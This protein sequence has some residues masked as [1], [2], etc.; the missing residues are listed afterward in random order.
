MLS[1]ICSPSE[2]KI[3]QM[4]WARLIPGEMA[5]VRTGVKKPPASVR[6]LAVRHKFAPGIEK[7][8]DSVLHYLVPAPLQSRGGLQWLR[9]LAADYT[10]ITLNW[11]VIG[12]VLVTWHIAFPDT[13]LFEDDAGRPGAFLGIGLL[14]AALITLMGYTEGIYVRG[15]EASAEAR[16]VGKSVLWATA[17][18][19]LAYG[20]QRASWSVSV[21]FWGAGVLDFCA[22]WGWRRW[23]TDRLGR[24]DIRRALIVGAG[25]VGRRIA[26]HIQQHPG[27]GRTVCGFLDDRRAGGNGVVGR[28]G[29]LAWAA[30]KQ[31]ADE[32]ILAAPHDPEI[33]RWVLS[34]A[35]RLRLDVE[36]VPDLYSCEPVEGDLESVGGLPAICLHAE[37]L[38]A[39]GLA[40]KRLAD[41]L[42]ATVSLTILSPLLAVIAILIKLDSQGPALYCAPRAGRKGQLFSCYKFRTMVTNANELKDRLRDSNE[43]SGPFFKMADDPRITRVGRYLRRYSLDELPQ[44]WNVLRGEMSLVGLRPHPL[45]DV[46]GYE[47][48]DLARLDVTPGMTGLW[49]I[50]A[51][52][53]PSFERGVEL[54]REYI[55]TWSLGSDLRILLRTIGVVVGGGG[56]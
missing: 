51:R 9:S 20:L 5:S 23:S 3:R 2:R 1:V 44:L 7:R 48:E 50:T 26:A 19:C 31:F 49:Q 27:N 10:L 14:H 21:L 30:R 28:V 34:E 24:R 8:R 15:H 17:V 13:W 55:R 12:A 25:K 45:D 16:I 36:I 29:D 22:L 46:A 40:L 11:L 33:T 52:S 37:R 56:E 53:D 38:P 6:T 4:E 18:M 47:L 39:V 43:R 54:D 41:V 42:G 35:R 32:I